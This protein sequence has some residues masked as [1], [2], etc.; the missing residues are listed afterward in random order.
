MRS[1]L[2]LTIILERAEGNIKY[3]VDAKVIFVRSTGEAGLTLNAKII[4]Y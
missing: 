1:S 3:Y 2:E 4:F